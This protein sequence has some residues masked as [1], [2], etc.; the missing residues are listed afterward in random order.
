MAAFHWGVEAIMDRVKE[1][2]RAALTR[3]AEITLFLAPALALLAVSWQFI[4][5]YQDAIVKFIVTL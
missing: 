2:T 1:A 5:R 4:S 3:T